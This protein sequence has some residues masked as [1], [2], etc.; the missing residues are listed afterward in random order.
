M[1]HLPCDLWD[2]LLGFDA[3]LAARGSLATAA[4]G[5]HRELAEVPVRGRQLSVC[6]DLCPRFADAAG[7]AVAFCRLARARDVTVS[8]AVAERRCCWCGTLLS[9]G[10]PLPC[11][12]ALCLI[13]EGRHFRYSCRLCAPCEAQVQQ[14]EDQEEQS[15]GD[16][17]DEYEYY[18]RGSAWGVW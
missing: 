10:A 4:G 9:P 6:A 5:L 17:H 14:M 16:E 15:L 11:D 12:C 3:G 18:D 8:W 1:P 13:L 7:E 2:R